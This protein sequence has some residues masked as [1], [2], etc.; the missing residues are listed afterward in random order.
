MKPRGPLQPWIMLAPTLVLLVVFFIVP[1]AVA[2]YESLFSWDL[3][4]PARSVGLDNYRQ[5]AARGDLLGVVL[6]TAG[7][8]VLVVS[9]TMVTGLSLAL[10]VHRPGPLFAF[11]RA[12]VF[13]AYVVSWVAVAL[14]WTWLLDGNAGVVGWAM[15]KLGAAP[16]P[17]L[18]DRRW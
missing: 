11:V 14:L 6:R 5:L 13:S 1:I 2:A 9:G 12:S 15:V 17:L 18:G 7:Y 3:L 10:L 4:T 8:S 16:W